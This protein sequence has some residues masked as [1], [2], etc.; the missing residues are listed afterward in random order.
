M[1]AF[2]I[3][4]IAVVIIGGGYLLMHK[5]PSKTA[6]TTP[7]T[8][9]QSQSSTPSSTPSQS[10]VDTITFDGNQFSPATL[11]VKSGTM[12]TIKNTSS[13]DVQMQSNPHPTHTDDNDLNVGLVAAG[14]SKTFTVTKTGS[15]GYHDHLDPSIQGKITIE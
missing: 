12:V 5:S 3:G 6:T 9:S 7:S 14:Q 11:T 15:F 13:Q 2:I 4:L 8:S 1:K 10:A